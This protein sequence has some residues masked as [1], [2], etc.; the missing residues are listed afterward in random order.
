MPPSNR[1]WEPLAA[2]FDDLQTA[3][4]S[5]PEHLFHDTDNPGVGLSWGFQWALEHTGDLVHRAAF[6]N[7]GGGW[8][9]GYGAVHEKVEKLYRAARE[10]TERPREHPEAV[11]RREFQWMHSGERIGA[12]PSWL[13][14][15]S[16]DQAIEVWKAALKRYAD[17]YRALVPLTRLQRMGRRAAISLGDLDLAGWRSTLVSMSVL[18]KDATAAGE[19][20]E[21]NLYF[22]DTTPPSRF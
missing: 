11:A 13:V 16:E 20:A 8:E 7:W 12:L 21:F 1:D 4:R 6:G 5:G 15:L 19:V 14:G 2:G 17:G 9:Y 22:R 3:Q 18:L 10:M